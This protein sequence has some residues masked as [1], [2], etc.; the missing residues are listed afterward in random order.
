M[1]APFH[2]FRSVIKFIRV[3][4]GHNLYRI[5]ASG[6][7]L[8]WKNEPAFRKPIQKRLLKYSQK[9]PF[10]AA[11]KIRSQQLPIAERLR[12]SS[13]SCFV[14]SISRRLQSAQVID[15]STVKYD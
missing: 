9:S 14:A 5:R 7:Y 1:T 15:Q 2:P 13:T 3:S 12:G 11:A 4:A 10:L 6:F 8:R